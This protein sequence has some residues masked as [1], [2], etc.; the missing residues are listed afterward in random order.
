MHHS[1]SGTI[2][3]YVSK[4]VDQKKYKKCAEVIKGWT[5]KQNDQNTKEI[6]GTLQNEQIIFIYPLTPEF[7]K[8]VHFLKIYGIWPLTYHVFDKGIANAQFCISFKV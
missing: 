4:R 2:Q 7:L 3:Y 8:P 6:K 1:I 5:L